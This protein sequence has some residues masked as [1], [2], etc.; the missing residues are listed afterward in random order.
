MRLG[1]S[2]ASAL[3]CATALALTGLLAPASLAG[4]TPQSTVAPVVLPQDHGA[5]PGFEVEWW[6]AAGTATSGGG[7]QYFWFATVWAGLGEL[8]AK[9][10]VVDLQADRIVLSHEYTAPDTLTGGQ[11]AIDVGGYGL[12]W[13]PAGILGR[14]S[15]D[16]PVP[17]GGGLDLE[18]M[19]S[20]PYVLHGLDGIIR[21]GSSALSDYYSDPRLAAQGTLTVNG[22][23]SPITGQGWFDHQWGNFAF[24]PSALHWNWFACQFDDGSDLMIYQ[25]ITRDGTPIGVEPV[26]YVSPSGTVS[27]PTDASVAPL[28]PTIQPPGATGTY[29]LRWQLDVPSANVDITLAARARAQ[30][31]TNRIVPSFWEGAAAI[32]AGRAGS[33]IVE[34]TR[35]SVLSGLL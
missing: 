34:S 3:V 31:I 2:W 23:M 5:H 25:F 7:R 21:Q 14:W 20:Q 15:I 16:A 13:Q 17:G 33:C 10:N 6:Y 24:S 35:E 26:T 19:P 32:T 8:V 12:S 18:L 22:Q 28:E 11:T 30:F 1:G 9:V 4:V 29:P 27:H